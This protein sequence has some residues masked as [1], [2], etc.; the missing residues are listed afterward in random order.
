MTLSTNWTS[1]GSA[2]CGGTCEAAV[3]VWP[4]ALAPLLV[5]A[6]LPGCCSPTVEVF[7]PAHCV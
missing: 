3:V 4:L 1:D 2:D 6:P 7:G 5:L